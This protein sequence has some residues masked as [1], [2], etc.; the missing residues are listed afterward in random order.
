MLSLVRSAFAIACR[1]CASGVILGVVIDIAFAFVAGGTQ[2]LVTRGPCN[3]L[4]AT[5]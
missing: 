4:I 5:R 1:P 2:Y 3:V